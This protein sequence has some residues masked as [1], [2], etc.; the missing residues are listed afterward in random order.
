M[1]GGVHIAI[2]QYIGVG[3]K[4]FV[5]IE[6]LALLVILDRRTDMD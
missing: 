6:V 1:N 5:V 4:V 3:G 2:H